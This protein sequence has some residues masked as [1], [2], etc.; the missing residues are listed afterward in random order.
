MRRVE[1][2]IEIGF[3]FEIRDGAWI[4]SKRGVRLQLDEGE[5]VPD[6][7][8]RGALHKKLKEDFVYFKEKLVGG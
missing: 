6:E 8:V 3:S 4:S 1:E 5:K 7:K 2:Y